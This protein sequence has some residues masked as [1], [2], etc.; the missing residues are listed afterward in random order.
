MHCFGPGR[1][2]DSSALLQLC[3]SLFCLLGDEDTQ[4]SKEKGHRTKQNS[5]KRTQE[6]ISRKTTS[7]AKNRFKFPKSTM[8]RKCGL[9]DCCPVLQK[10]GFQKNGVCRARRRRRGQRKTVMHATSRRFR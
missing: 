2:I 6:R 3:L 9:V 5:N 8:F 4:G 7:S 1:I 10:V